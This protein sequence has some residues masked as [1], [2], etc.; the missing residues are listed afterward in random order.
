MRIQ[1]GLY[2]SD[3]SV[4]FFNVD[5]AGVTAVFSHAL[6]DTD[7]LEKLNQFLRQQQPEVFNV[8]LDLMGEEYK[9]ESVP[10]LAGRD[11]GLLLDRKSK[12]LFPNAD[13]VWKKHLRREKIG[14]K[15]DVYLLVGLSLPSSIEHIFDVLAKSK[16]QIAGV[17]SLSILEQQ[18][19][20][21]LKMSEQ[22]LLVSRV[23]GSP[24]GKRIYRQTFF[25]AG[26]LAMSR[27]T[28]ISG[29]TDAEVFSQL[30]IEIER[31]RRFLAGTRQLNTANKL[32]VRTVFSEEEASRFSQHETN[33]ERLEIESIQLLD[34]A[35]SNG[36]GQVEGFS[37]L[38]ELL[39]V[40]MSQKRISSH[41]R[42]K[43][44]TDSFNLLK[45]KRL[46]G[47]VAAGLLLL[48]ACVAGTVAYTAKL[49]NE[50]LQGLNARVETLKQ[51]RTSLLDNVQD[52]EISATKMK[53]IVELYNDISAY[54]FGP[55][56]VLMVIAQ[57]YKGFKHISIEE[58]TWLAEPSEQQRNN[59]GRRGYSEPFM[60]KLKAA[61]QF[62]LKVALPSNLG[63]RLI[64]ENMELFSSALR[65]QAEITEVRRERAMLNTSADAEMAGSLGETTELNK[66]VEFTL[67]ITM[68]L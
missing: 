12:S 18:V 26:Q 42:P 57:A 53:Q 36:L 65:K 5:Q 39:A 55:D 25:R 47:R 68:E 34:L 44:L 28:S 10:H 46:M 33:N 67:L 63:N 41:F 48:S 35:L 1:H 6:S 30:M 58:I 13:F 29:E 49:E 21:N 61:R 19:H 24:E 45:T 50:Q 38:A 31:M 15:D 60:T 16:R 23:L 32:V 52:T 17:Y 27:V 14:R 20:V 56:K 37:S 11:R 2:L 7:Y 51:Q 54:Q 9:Q 8:Y 64:L 62:E 59:R 22:S 66:P 4:I 43:G 40:A 3:V